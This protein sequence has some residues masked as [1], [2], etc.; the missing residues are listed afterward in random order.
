MTGTYVPT[1]DE[2]AV[3]E[4][5]ALAME[6]NLAAAGQATHER[7][8]VDYF[9]LSDQH[10][11]KLPDGISWVAHRELNEGQKA[12]YQDS[13]QRDVTLRK[14]TGDAQIKMA[15]GAER[16]ELV[17]VALVDWNIIRDGKPL[18]FNPNNVNAF[19]KNASPKIIDL[20]EKS[21][22][23]ENTWLMEEVSSKDL[24]NEIETL[25]ELLEAKRKE[26]EGKDAS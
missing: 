7:V 21:I 11:V 20:I 10:I 17:K 24:E 5:R 1:D 2:I 4:Q 19:V 9:G 6:A 13:L 22:R 8:Q 23:K 16:M 12:K 15:M 25:Q 3:Q 18:A 14:S 26:E